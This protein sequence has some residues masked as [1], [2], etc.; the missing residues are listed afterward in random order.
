MSH[1]Y[2]IAVTSVGVLW[3]PGAV[4]A[5]VTS[6]PLE[7]LQLAFERNVGRYDK[8]VQFVTRTRG[9][10]IFL[11]QNE[12]VMVLRG[13]PRGKRTEAEGPRSNAVSPSPR[14]R[15]EGRGE[16]RT[17]V[18]R[19]KLIGA[20]DKVAA[21]G[22]QKRPGIVNYLIGNNPTQWHTSVPTFARAKLAGVYPRI[23]VVYYGREARAERREPETDGRRSLS[24]PGSQLS[25]LEYDFIVK[26]GADPKRIRLAFEGA[27]DM[28][29]CDGHIVLTTPAGDVR[30][31]RPVAYQ[32]ADGRRTNVACSFSAGRRA[33][34]VGFQL[35]RYDAS[36]PLVIDPVLEY[37]AFLGGSGADEGSGIAVDAAGSAYIVGSTHSANYPTTPGAYSTAKGSGWD[38]CVTKLSPSGDALVYSTFI[39]G[40]GSDYG[41]DIAVD[42]SGA[43]F[44]VGHTDSADFPTTAGAFDTTPNGGVDAFATRLG[45]AGDALAH[46]TFLGGAQDDQAYAIAL[47]PG[48]SAYLAG[49]TESGAFPTTAGAYVS[50]W[51]GNTDCF[52]TKMSPDG[53]TLAYSA[54]VSGSYY[55]NCHD[56]VVDG[57]GAAYIVGETRSPNFVTTPGAFDTTFNDPTYLL[58]DAFVVKLNPAGSAMDYS[59]LLGGANRDEGRGIAVDAAG[60]AYVTGETESADFPTTPGAYDTTYSTYY[61]VFVTKLNPAGSALV[62]STYLGNTDGDWGTGI[63][64][65]S[66]GTVYVAGRTLGAAFPTTPDAFDATHNGD[67]DAYLARLN[68][69]GT[70]LLYSTFLGGSRDDRAG[71]VWVDGADWVYVVGR[72][73]S[74]G[75][76]TTAGAYDTS[77]NGDTD[78]F[79]AKFAAPANT[80]LYAQDRTGTITE[81][82]TLRA[83][84]RRLPDNAWLV[85]KT[86]EF[87]VDSTPVGGAATNSS[88][89]AELNWVIPDGALTRTIGAAFAG[90]GQYNPSSDT[91]A[92]TCQSWTTKM[93][94]FDRTACITDRTELKCRLLRSDNTPLYNKSINFY[95][96]GTFVIVRP[97]NTTGYA[98]YPYYTVPDGTGAGTR[99]ILSEWTGNGGYAAV[100]KT[101]NLTVLKAITYIWVLPKTIPQGAIANLYALFRRLYDYQKQVGKTVDFKIDGTVVQT[102]VT[103]SNG[104]ARYLYP[105]SEPAGIHTIRCE[106]AGDAWLDSGYGQANLTIY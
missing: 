58:T 90:D 9:A 71:R 11:T 97:T 53:A 6:V 85:G 100:S 51:R 77:F 23:D 26:P 34:T 94:T 48:G 74:S 52:V 96:D 27:D 54:I 105:S 40:A 14:L 35:A 79:A 80:S 67:M 65:D 28:R 19:M 73:S 41:A 31:K 39:G 68:A 95:V 66:L 13:K 84:L 61:D 7:R 70:A 30:L 55:D 29:I 32:L 82:V 81:I 22:L 99:T 3:A 2:V 49:D 59:T 16:G 36:R 88:G 92:L 64:L 10:T 47:D 45:P 15:G 20:S 93:A 42:A 46:S 38:V 89:R 72:T 21:T 101:A 106:F 78:I 62:Y 75:F 103:D 87:S 104:V 18:V 56:L 37:S 17:T 98:S 43:A 4:R 25:A 24:A 12:M 102:V 86:I 63:A 69:E 57:T 91:A 50:A 1:R 33:G 5:Q 8:R 44:V 83:Y 76:P 60:C